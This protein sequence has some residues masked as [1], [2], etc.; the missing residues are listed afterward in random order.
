MSFQD[1][2]MLLA[3]A[4]TG[5]ALCPGLWGLRANTAQVQ[6]LAL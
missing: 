4:C 3:S 5:K 1:M 6:T 2:L